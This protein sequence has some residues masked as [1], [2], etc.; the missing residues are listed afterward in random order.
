MQASCEDNRNNDPSY[1]RY[2]EGIRG[3]NGP[4]KLRRPSKLPGL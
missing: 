2:I 1:F 3:D 4:I